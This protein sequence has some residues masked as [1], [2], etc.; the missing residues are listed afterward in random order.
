MNTRGFFVALGVSCL[1]LGMGA[2][3][4]RADAWAL[5]VGVNEYEDRNHIASLGTA[6]QDAIALKKLLIETMKVP[7][8]HID[9]LVTDPKA[10]TP[11]PTRANILDA[12]ARLKNNVK[13]GDTVYVFFSGHGIQIDQI[14]YLL[15]YDFRGNADTGIDTALS[16]PRFYQ[17]L[18]QVKARAVILA[19]DK[20]R[21]NPFPEK[22]SAEDNRN[23]L[24]ENTDAD[25]KKGWVTTPVKGSAPPP[26]PPK[27][28]PPILVKFFACSP[29][30][31]A[32]EWRD[33]GRGYFSYFFEKG[34]RGA[35]ADKSGKVTIGTLA[36]Y[37]QTEIQAQVKRDENE[38]QTPYPEINGP[39]APD[40]ILVGDGGDIPPTPET[41]IVAKRAVTPESAPPSDPKIPFDPNK[42]VSVNVARIIIQTNVPNL[43]MTL[44]DS[45]EVSGISETIF[46]GKRVVGVIHDFKADQTK[47][48]PVI[49]SVD[50]PGYEP[51]RFSLQ[52]YGGTVTF[53]NFDDLSLPP[54]T[55]SKQAAPANVAKLLAAHRI[56]ALAALGKL[57][58]QIEPPRFRKMNRFP[59][60][61]VI[62]MLEM[63]ENAPEDA[64]D[65]RINRL[66]RKIK[67]I[68]QGEGNGKPNILIP[69]W[70][71]LRTLREGGA[72]Y[73]REG[74]ALVVT[75]AMASWRVE[76]TKDGKIDRIS[77][78]LDGK[79]ISV[80]FVKYQDY[81]G[82]PLP[83]QIQTEL[84]GKTGVFIVKRVDKG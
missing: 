79:P 43:T 71:T 1:A 44:N 60:Y 13:T 15:P 69:F 53:R 80:R 14:D 42:P 83:Q 73:S 27:D 37:L 70:Q 36:Q 65:R 74:E 26:P 28:A 48:T 8:R 4:A 11:K 25:N 66:D 21:N 76:M 58:F 67:K 2:R 64:I 7:E 56:D 41:K 68:E 29:G 78:E 39:N 32:Y 59:A 35:A 34:L 75:T 20:C 22:K 82:V 3:T 17:L 38:D 6:D 61:T 49:L 9:L 63:P 55:V 23:H 18:S 52:L 5:L 50:T 30:Q 51:Q 40:F 24:P 31:T 57:K 84:N 77:G 72:S 16:E 12:L 81:K 10:E 33:K 46:K 62:G 54:L 19:W 45:V 47:P